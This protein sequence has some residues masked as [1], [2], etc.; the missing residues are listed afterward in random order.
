MKKLL[1]PLLVTIG[2]AIATVGLVASERGERDE[3]HEHEYGGERHGLDSRERSREDGGAGP[4]YFSDTGYELYKTECGSCHM[5]YPPFMLP[6][7]SWNRIIGALGD[8][9]GDDA[10][11]DAATA[12]QI[13]DFLARNS[14]GGGRGD[15]AEGTG[16]AIKS[17]MPPPRITS[18]DYFRGQHHEIPAK[19]VTDNP[20]VG[21]FARCE[22][23]HE[24][25]ERGDFD[26]RGVRIPGYFRWDD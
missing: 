1:T 7:A 4:A 25:A 11:L 19:M 17:R 2:V 26:E 15:Y 10:E 13:A 23:C 9:F 18:T 12:G 16:P 6:A 24:G 20:D 21:S 5:A 14:A 3:A 22:T 8:H